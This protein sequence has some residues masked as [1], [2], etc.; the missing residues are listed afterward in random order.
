MKTKF[1]CVAWVLSLFIGC[2]QDDV[3]DSDT[4][5]GEPTEDDT[6]VFRDMSDDEAAPLFSRENVVEV[7]LSLPQDAWE[8]LIEKARDEQYTI[9]DVTIMG[10]HFNEVGLRF[11]GSFGTLYNCFDENNALICDKL[12]MKIKFNE[13]I[14]EQRFLGL[15]RVNLQSWQNDGTKLKDCLS[16][17]IFRETGIIAPRCAWANV[18]VND[19]ALGLFGLVEQ[20]DGRFTDSRF[21][22][23]DGNLYKE[24]WP[25][26]PDQSYYEER[27]RTN[28][29]TAE[30]D[31]FL[32]FAEAM[33]ATNDETLPQTLSRF[34]D[35]DYIIRYMAVDFAITNWDGITTFYC[36]EWGCGNHNFYIYQEESRP[37]FWLIPWDL[38]ATFLTN[39]WIEDIE[40]WDNLDASCDQADYGG[41]ADLPVRPAGCDQTIRAIALADRERYE[42][43]LSE[44]LE[45]HLAQEVIEEKIDAMV[46]LIAPYIEADP[47]QYYEEW[48]LTV[49]WQ[50]EEIEGIRERVRREIEK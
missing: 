20:V 38:E 32:A 34:M 2:N 48:L 30:H 44:I 23:G 35:I 14:E 37:F 9:A 25:V 28:E 36:G 4:D 7:R 26:S 45:T 17:D 49:L 15:K 24:A 31:H 12:S 27:L 10:E 42:R 18:F 39:S 19:E 33:T 47:D 5:R 11:K 1:I 40:P 13:Y 21:E 46:R 3:E 16:Y 6:D 22:E 43:Y 8:A 29:E 50:I 41:T